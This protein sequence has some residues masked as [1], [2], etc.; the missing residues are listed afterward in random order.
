M[1]WW[2]GLAPLR[3]AQ[4]IRLCV[5][6]CT[7]P[8]FRWWG[9]PEQARDDA[10][11]MVPAVLDEDLVGVVPCHHDTRDKDAG[12]RRLQCRGIVRRNPRRRVDGNT[13]LTQERHV[14]RKAG[15]D[16]DARRL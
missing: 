14:R 8:G 15:H 12:N 9:F 10:F 7:D 2:L 11:A 13:D 6:L 1:G 16:V 4:T 5:Q 3:F